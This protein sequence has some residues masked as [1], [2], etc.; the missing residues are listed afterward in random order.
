M[1][2]ES[3]FSTHFDPSVLH[4]LD[5]HCK[6]IRLGPSWLITGGS[7]KINGLYVALDWQ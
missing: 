3:L 5:N 7:Y 1:Q 4:F 2:N 6:Q